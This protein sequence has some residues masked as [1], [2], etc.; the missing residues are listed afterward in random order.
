MF[1]PDTVKH[2]SIRK[3]SDVE[4]R[5]Q[6]GVHPTLPLVPTQ[7]IFNTPAFYHI[8]VLKTYVP[9]SKIISVHP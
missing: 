3:D 6:Y 7:P 9:P 5:H 2:R 1:V 4:V 8:R